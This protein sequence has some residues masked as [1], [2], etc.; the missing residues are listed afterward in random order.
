MKTTV[1]RANEIKREWHLIDATDKPLG[2]I[3]VRIA[4]VLRG[5]TKP[6]FIS[7][8]DTGD[9]V[10]V[11]NAGKVCLTGRKEK[12]KIYKHYTGY[13]RGLKEYPA[14]IIREKNPTRM[15]YDAVRRML[16]KN[17]LMR[18]TYKRLKV[19][20]DGAHPH[21]AQSPRPLEL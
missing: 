18:S 1:P 14:S 13:R 21:V 10:V 9:F 6:I 3:A 16:P 5:K 2:R 15:I 4:D 20:S 8:I 19:Y 11:V 7:H 12:Q 17:R